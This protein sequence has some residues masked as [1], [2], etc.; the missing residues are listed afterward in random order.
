MPPIGSKSPEHVEWARRVN[1][2]WIVHHGLK[3]CAE[4][5]LDHL[6]AMAPDRLARS[7]WRAHRLARE[8][9]PG[10][11]PKP[12][13]YAGLFSL[14][15]PDEAERFLAD[16]WFT[17]SCLPSPASAPGSG[18]TPAGIGPETQAKLERIRDAVAA[19]PHEE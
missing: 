19:L 1:S 8:C 15:T 14:A 13:F 4:A 12:W 11:D 3:E 16:H 10:E 2:R 17:A 18:T 7:C 6:E 5:Y 9:E